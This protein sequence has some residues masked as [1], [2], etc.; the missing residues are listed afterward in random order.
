MRSRI[1]VGVDG[2]MDKMRPAVLRHALATGQEI[3]SI[4][5]RVYSVVQDPA[6]LVALPRIVQAWASA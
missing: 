1:V 5:T 4:L 6:A 3:G 2:S